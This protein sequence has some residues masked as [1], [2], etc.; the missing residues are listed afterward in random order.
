M[1]MHHFGAEKHGVQG[2]VDQKDPKKIFF[3]E[4]VFFLSVFLST[5][6]PT[7][8]TSEPLCCF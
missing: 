1:L 4:L 7:Q 5:Q 8:G 3:F 2:L 6:K